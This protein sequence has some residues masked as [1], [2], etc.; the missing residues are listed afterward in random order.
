M[1]T[2]GI[3]QARMESTRLPN[4]VLAA[5]AGRPLL[6]VL[7]TRIRSAE[8]VD[9][10]WLATT[11]RASD[12][13]LARKGEEL[14]L[15]VYRG[16]VDDVLD[17]YLSVLDRDPAERVVRITA[18]DPFTDGA[19]IDLAL[20]AL[21]VSGDRVD[22]MSDY[23][24]RHYPLGYA[25]YV[26]FSEALR[27]AASDIPA[28]ESWHRVHAGISWLFDHGRCADWPPPDQRLSRS[29]WRWTVDTPAD[30]K[31]AQEAFGAFGDR[32]A[33]IDYEDMVGILDKLPEVTAHNQDIQ[34]KT[35]DEG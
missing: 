32:W 31:M 21:D 8:K 15:S 14:G 7:V 22:V 2:I 30:L 6:E 1:T 3:I 11:E 12:D 18:D 13:V 10:Y 26:V 28:D 19:I 16:S 24:S 29:G 23:H 4:K 35:S 33:D 20:E 9:K 17:R 27:R 34:Q 25:P 5:V